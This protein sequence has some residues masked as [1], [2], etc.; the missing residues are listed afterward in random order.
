MRAYLLFVLKRFAQLVAVIAVGV[1]VAFFVTHL[2]PINPVDQAMSRITARS[3]FSPDSILEL[4]EALSE[5]YGLERPMGEMF[6]NFWRRAVVGDFGPSIMA[7][8]TPAM[9]LVMR[10][11]PWTVGL[12]LVATILC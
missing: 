10:A 5:M 1:S 11:L 3:S 9:Q 4:R 2:S 6:V 8:P 12:L 7:F